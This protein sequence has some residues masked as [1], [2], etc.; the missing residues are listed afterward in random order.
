M[1]SFLMYL[2]K[3]SAILSLFYLV[4]YFF[5]RKETFFTINRHFLL[6]GILSSLLL[7]FLEFTTIEF[8]EKPSFDTIEFTSTLSSSSENKSIYISW[9]FITFMI[10]IITA[11]LLFCRFIF[12]LITLQRIFSKSQNKK[13]EGF[14]ILKT[15]EN[16]APFSFFKYIIFN[17]LLHNT[18]ELKMILKHEKIH[19][20]QHHS[21]DILL[22]NLLVIFQWINPV[23][24]LYKKSLQQNLEFIADQEAIRDLPSKKEYQLTLVKVSSNNFSSITNNFYQSLIKKRIVMLNKKKSNRQNLWKIIIVL[25]LLSLFLWGFNTETEIQYIQYETPE[26]YASQN[27]K[28]REETFP[29]K[30]KNYVAQRTASFPS[31]E[32]SPK[33]KEQQGTNTEKTGL[34][35]QVENN[36]PINKT[37][38]R[39][40]KV[41]K[42]EKNTVEFII[43]K[44]STKEDL[45]RV[46]RIFKNEY[47]VEI[48]FTDVKR[49]DANEITSISLAM[50]SKKSNANFSVANETPIHPLVISYDSKKGKINIGQ[51]GDNNAWIHRDKH[52][53]HSDTQVIEVYSDDEGERIFIIDADKKHKSKIQQ[54][55]SKKNKIILRNNDD[56]ILFRANVH[57]TIFDFDS[58]SDTDP[59]FFIDGKKAS[60]KK[61]KKLK[62]IEIQSVDVSKGKTSVKKYGKKA[63]DGVIHITT[64]KHAK[65]GTGF[66][67]KIIKDNIFTGSVD[68]DG[69]KPLMFVDGKKVDYSEIQKI[70]QK[71]IKS[72][73]IYKDIKAITR[74]GSEGEN[75]VIEIILK[76]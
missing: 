4:Y 16:I 38:I 2:L 7:P 49:N 58:I 11:T 74:F 53:K 21:I 14:S 34:K 60:K 22:T 62:S 70:D 33:R 31:K 73:N 35:N 41:T 5:L 42:T 45:E 3:S 54:K 13:N 29:S 15:E 71:Q 51:S 65:K 47:I 23:A 28:Q 27:K 63:K 43:D 57:K 18:E 50:T 56:N 9:L 17:P 48:I 1:E 6:A 64:K 26:Q 66:D 69:A 30:E 20:K 67:F 8:I 68:D 24:W 36:S 75:G 44:N 59:L 19:V 55:K 61:V 39:T 25:P 46:K 37:S 72:V 52:S 40:Q 12:Q 76:N 32:E 10:Y